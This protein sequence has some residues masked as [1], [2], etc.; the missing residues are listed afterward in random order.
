MKNMT[1]DETV[2]RH[3]AIEWLLR[4]DCTFKVLMDVSK[5]SPF[6]IVM[7]LSDWSEWIQAK[8]EEVSAR[9]EVTEQERTEGY[10]LPK[11]DQE[12]HERSKSRMDLA[13][14]I[15]MNRSNS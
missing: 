7:M 4:N 15:E 14:T 12:R 2:K 11:N 1:F 10:P 8:V 9:M 13:K 3:K 5:Q 6:N